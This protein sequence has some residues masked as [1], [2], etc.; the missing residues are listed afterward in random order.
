MGTYCGWQNGLRVLIT[1]SAAVLSFHSDGSVQY[2]GFDLSFSFLPLGEFLGN[3]L[4]KKC[5]NVKVGVL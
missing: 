3:V 2:K 5:S 1:S 4:S